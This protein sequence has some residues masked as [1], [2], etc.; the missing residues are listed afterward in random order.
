[1]KHPDGVYTNFFCDLREL[2]A[3]IKISD[4]V[5]ANDGGPHHIAIAVDTPSLAIFSPIHSKWRWIPEHNHR[6]QGVDM[7]DV[8][9][10]TTQQ[11]QERFA[12]FQGDLEKYYRMITPRIVIHRAENMIEDLMPRM[13]EQ[14]AL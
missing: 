10:I 9:G 5:I 14:K 11:H 7:G 4:Y 3:L 6:H 13:A 1:M 12:E 2:A 8:L